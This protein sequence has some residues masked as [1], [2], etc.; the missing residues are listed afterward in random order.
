MQE[1]FP[2]HKIITDIG[3]GLNFRR[4]GLQTALEL[5]SKG[6][7]SEVVVAYRDR[8]CRFAFELYLCS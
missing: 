4:K 7:V 8:L 1:K 3:S 6:R 2:E 5:A